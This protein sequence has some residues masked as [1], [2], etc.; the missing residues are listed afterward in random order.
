MA[1]MSKYEPGMFC[2]WELATSDGN[3]AKRFYSDL[4][5]WT[6]N[7]YPMGDQPPYVM[8]QKDGR[9][10]GALYENKN[11]PP[12]WLPYVAVASADDAAAKAKSLGAKLMSDP[13]DV[14]DAGRMC[15][16]A[17]PE[18]ARIALWQPNKH[19]GAGVM[20]EPGSFCWSELMT[21][22]AA[23]AM[24]FYAALFGW[25]IKKSPEYNEIHIGEQP[26]GGIMPMPRDVPP[27]VPAHWTSYVMVADVDGS[28]KKL[29]GDGGG[30]IVPPTDIQKVGRFAVVHDPQ[31]ASFALYKMA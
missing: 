8:L 4:F 18:G 30:V 3:A 7:E 11:I 31:G 21:R 28:V 20:G 15:V 26:V 23:R 27:Q 16:V 1:V 29:Q 6:A 24:D 25:T 14:F 2:W 9:D 10:V 22:D 19:P 17:D 13:F 5:G 12:N